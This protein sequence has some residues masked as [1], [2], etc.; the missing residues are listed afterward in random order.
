MT[1]WY[2]SVIKCNS[3]FKSDHRT[4]GGWGDGKGLPVPYLHFEPVM[5]SK[6]LTIIFL[7]IIYEYVARILNEANAIIRMLCS[8][9]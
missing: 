4:D 9:F 5:I 2:F 8:L 1:H 3:C 6:P 7:N